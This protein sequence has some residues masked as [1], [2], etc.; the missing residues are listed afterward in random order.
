MAAERRVKLSGGKK[1]K[2][3]F[4]KRFAEL[5]IYWVAAGAEL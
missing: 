3:D 4:A 5:G 1:E 2:R